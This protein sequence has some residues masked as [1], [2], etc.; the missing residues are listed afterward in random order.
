MLR[1]AVARR[2]ADETPNANATNAKW[3]LHLAFRLLPTPA[4]R[5]ASATC[6]ALCVLGVLGGGVLRQQARGRCKVS[7][8]S[9]PEQLNHYRI[10]EPLGKGG[11]GE[12]FAAEDTRLHR[13][14][15]LKVLSALMAADPERRQRFE[16]EA[17]AVAAINHPNIVTIH[18]VEE[19]GGIP[20]L[21]MELVEGKALNEIVAAGALPA[22]AL[23]RIGISISDAIAAAHQRGITHRDLKPANIMVA[24]DGRVKVLDFGLAKLREAQLAG[25]AEDVTRMP[26]TDLTG[27]GRI[28]GTVAY[29]SPEQAEG[30]PVDS[31]TDIFSLGVMLHEMATGEKPFKGD[32][33]VSVISSIL[34]DTPSS[35]TDL[36]PNLPAGLARVIRRTLAKDP[37]RRYQTATDLRNELEELKQEVDSGVTMSMNRV[38]T[39]PRIQNRTKRLTALGV[40]IVALIGLAFGVSKWRG[41]ASVPA[42]AATFEADRFTR[43]TNTGNAFLAA[44]SP[45]GNYVVHVKNTGTVPALWIRQ[46]A[47]TSDVQIVPPAP[48]RYDGIAYSPDGTHVFYSTYSLTGGVATLYKVPVLGGTP[49]PVLEDVDSRISFSPDRKQFAFVRGAPAQGTAYLMTANADGTNPRQLAVLPQGQQ[50]T[51]TAVA[52]SPDGKTILVPGR[53]RKDGPHEL[54]VAVDATSGAPTDLP[55]RWAFIADVEWLPDGRSFGLVAAG[56]SA[57]GTQIWQVPYPSGEPRRI[58]NDLNNYLG[59]AF[60]ADGK[61]MVTVQAENVSNLWVAPATDLAGG[62]QITTGRSRGDGQQGIAWTPDGRIVFASLASGKPD[63]WI[64]AADGSNARQL[65]SA[66][67]ASVQPSVTKDGKY[68]VFQRFLK[69][70]AHIWRMGLDGS[71]PKQLTSRDVELSPRAGTDFVFYNIPTSGSPKPWKVSID[72]GEPTLMLDVYFRPLDVSPDATQLLGVGWDQEARRAVLAIMPTAGGALQP[73]PELPTFGS[74]WTPDGRGVTYGGPGGGAFQIFQ[75]KLGDKAPKPIARFEDNLFGFA[76]SPDGKRAA[77]SR[78]QSLSDVVMI[79]A[80]GKTR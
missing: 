35:I 75:Y 61:S 58:T 13:K 34:K 10:L 69:D 6:R 16:R 50:F 59:V 65:T 54:I 73:I 76:W 63:I 57:G 67:G 70:S 25:N 37:S 14:V 40:A 46:T 2:A 56:F 23:L 41:R 12:V 36:N 64:S 77:L 30:K 79:T 28:I 32:T 38:T 39:S 26:V 5:P 31:R 8:V 49:H 71:D 72:G 66:D 21:T 11:M 62:K 20:F 4:E 53:S 15:A 45:D 22:E 74:V 42:T 78:G 43:L 7:A 52:W 51:N 48:V 68:I 27:E 60:A 47:T 1:R 3:R 29:M 80:K 18:S 17:Q 24:P 33:N 44:I 19:A 9:I 55:G